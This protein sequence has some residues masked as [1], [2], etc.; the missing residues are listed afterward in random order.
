MEQLR[1]IFA[2]IGVGFSLTVVFFA[3]WAILEI[4]Q[5]KLSFKDDGREPYS[6]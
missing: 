1:N 5:G 6:F 2:A 4:C 3:A